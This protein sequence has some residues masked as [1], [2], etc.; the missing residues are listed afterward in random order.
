MAKKP[1]RST[2]Q[3][4]PSSSPK[5]RRS[6]IEKGIWIVGLLVILA[7]FGL[8]RYREYSRA[9]DTELQFAYFYCYQKI[10]ELARSG[11]LAGMKY[12]YES[13]K[14]FERKVQDRQGM[15]PTVKKLEALYWR[16]QE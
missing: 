14:S 11:D 2:T 16:H 10:K 4:A 1:K 5:R 7:A 8:Y 9:R 12:Y 15:E 13:A 3:S 6:K